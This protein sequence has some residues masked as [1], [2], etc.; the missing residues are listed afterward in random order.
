MSL[1]AR[2]QIAGSV[3]MASRLLPR[4]GRLTRVELLCSSD[5]FSISAK[6]RETMRVASS[7]VNSP[8]MTKSLEFVVFMLQIATQIGRYS[9]SLSLTSLTHRSR[10][11]SVAIVTQFLIILS[12]VEARAPIVQAVTEVWRSLPCFGSA[13]FW[14]F[15]IH[16]TPL[17]LALHGRNWMV[18]CL[19]NWLYWLSLFMGLLGPVL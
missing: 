3:V 12:I 1:H 14:I 17:C 19:L 18:A 16:F 15:G 4:L 10:L 2:R 7:C 5:L 11:L 6:S 9:I 13:V 8:I